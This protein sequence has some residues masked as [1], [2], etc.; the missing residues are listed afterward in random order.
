M[1][2]MLIGSPLGAAEIRIAGRVLMPGAPAAAVAAARV[3]LGPAVDGYEAARRWLAGAPA[4]APL[5]STHPAPDGSF[6]LPAPQPGCYRLT[7]SAEGYVPLRF[8]LVP[9]VEDRVLPA[10]RLLPATRTTIEARGEGGEPLPGVLIGVTRV[11]GA[12][13][14]PRWD[15]A[16]RTGRTGA[17]GRLTVPRG[18]D[19]QLWAMSLDPRFKG[20]MTQLAETVTR[21]RLLRSR[22]I[23][24]EAR[25]A[26]GRPVAGALLRRADGQPVALAGDDGRLA[27]DDDEA[28][29]TF[30]AVAMTLECPAGDSGAAI[31]GKELRGSPARGGPARVTLA[32]LPMVAGELIDSA[33]HRP[34]AGGLVWSASAELPAAT[35]S[36]AG[37]DGRFRLP[38]PAAPSMQLN[39]AAP[40]YLPAKTIIRRRPGEAPAAVRIELPRAAALSGETVDGSGAPVAGAEV[41]VGEATPGREPLGTFVADRNGRFRLS[42]LA[43]G[44]RY[45]LYTRAPGFA[46]GLTI[47]Q[48]PAAAA[49]AAVPPPEESP[50]S[51][52]AKPLRIVLATGSSIV[53][54]IVDGAGRPLDGVQLRLTPTAGAF[55]WISSWCGEDALRTVRSGRAGTFELAHLAANRYRLHAAGPGLAPWSRE[56]I[57]VSDRTRRIDLGTL[58]MQ[59]GGVL[60]AQVVDSRGAPV[61]AASAML[62][63]SGEQQP[64]ALE[65]SLPSQAVTGPDGRVRF[66]D[67]VPGA[68]YDLEIHHSEHPETAVKCISIPTAGLLRIELQEGRRLTGRVVGADGRPIAGA[69]I[70]VAGSMLQGSLAQMRAPDAVTDAKGEFSLS[71]LTAGTVQLQVTADGFRRSRAA[72]P[73]P[74]V[75]P[76]RP[77]EIVL[78][79]AGWLVGSVRDVA[80][81]PVGA[82]VTVMPKGIQFLSLDWLE[83][84]RM[85]PTD[86]GGEYRVDGLDPGTYTVTAGPLRRMASGKPG[87]PIEIRLGPNTLDIVVESE[88][89]WEVSGQVVDSAGN[90][91]DN[92]TLQ[93]TP[94]AD[95]AGPVTASLADGSFVFTDVADG[96]Y[97]PGVRGH[98][99]SMAA[100][101]ASVTVAGGPVSGLRLSL[102]RT[103]AMISGRLLHLVPAEMA[104]VRIEAKRIGPDTFDRTLRSGWPVEAGGIAVDPSSGSYQITD[105]AAGVWSVTATAADRHAGGRVDLDSDRA[106]AVLD[107]EFAGGAILSG[108]VTMAERPV[109]GLLVVLGPSSA[110]AGTTVAQAE[111]AADGT[112]AL[113]SLPLGTY[114]LGIV[115]FRI[116]L[117]DH[118]TVELTADQSLDISLPSGAVHGTVSARATGLPISGAYVV[119]TRSNAPLGALAGSPAAAQTDDSGAFD[120]AAVAPGH[121]QVTATRPGFAPGQDT[122]DVTADGTAAIAMELAAS[123]TAPAEP[124]AAAEP[125]APT[126]P[127][128]PP[129]PPAEPNSPGPGGGS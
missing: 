125:A 76:A 60:E 26:E 77:V 43:A 97:T 28:P 59:A 51:V 39:A 80:G 53:G 111:T 32:P 81:N 46:A 113:P 25:D 12:L 68:R 74:D 31:T 52:V 36:P 4:A 75:E 127:A 109:A 118:R 66:A 23:E 10:V 14:G 94:A 116:G 13:P 67:L 104:G 1:A 124:A 126:E 6:A 58:T 110:Q 121:Y 89:A 17:D 61:P 37:P 105:L 33:S 99:Y 20:Q 96:T 128:E 108:R 65:D 38:M 63:A 7:V 106:M 120:I 44:V 22:T 73:I 112:F 55:S 115:D 40:G 122:L 92:V 18:P 69:A 27:V 5:A 34:I 64:L 21:L 129:E 29:L 117:L 79:P 83:R 16:S 2:R 119:L 93:L 8:P 56:L 114:E 24:L 41:T 90:P 19:E 84:S 85:G 3:E 50:P 54:K 71:G 72:A 70:G 87:P 45:Y 123:S 15:V 82:M 49:A 78:E 100:G 103:E 86:A 88:N 62:S 57:E 30:P 9:L 48:A 102:S 95:G 107:L 11:M 35:S 47:V 42:S 91:V 98:G 101:T